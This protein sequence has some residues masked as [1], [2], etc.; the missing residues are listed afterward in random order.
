MKISLALA[1]A[2]LGTAAPAVI[3]KAADV[4]PTHVA[5]PIFPTL[6]CIDD[7]PEQ[8]CYWW[9]AESKAHSRRAEAVADAESSDDEVEVSIG[10][11]STST[12]TATKTSVA[13]TTKIQTKTQAAPTTTRTATVTSTKTASQATSSATSVESLDDEAEVFLD[14]DLEEFQTI[15]FYS[16]VAHQEDTPYPYE[17]V[18]EDYNRTAIH[19]AIATRRHDRY[20]ASGCATHCNEHRACDAFA[21]YIER[22]PPCNN[23]SNPENVELKKCDLYNTRLQRPDVRKESEKQ[24]VQ[25]KTITRAVRAYNGY[26]RIQK[27]ATVTATRTRTVTVRESG[28]VE[29]SIAYRTRTV[30]TTAR[31]A[32][33]TVHHTMSF[34]R[35]S[36]VTRSA[37]ASTRTVTSTKPTTTVTKTSTTSGSASKTTVTKTSTQSTATVTKTSTRSGSSK[38]TTVTQTSTKST[39]TV[40]QTLTKS[41]ATVTKTS[42]KSGSAE[43]TT[44]TVTSTKTSSDKHTTKTR[45]AM[46]TTTKSLK[47][48][49]FTSTQTRTVVIS[50]SAST[51]AEAESSDEEGAM[52]W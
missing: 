28:S 13:T 20:D 45:T 16:R 32:T 31:P 3:T 18:I 41:T 1:L 9:K 25:G 35:N 22:E 49:T 8:M 38:P 34:G 40:T 47:T 15:P 12:K 50:A 52:W 33:T 19:Q 29:V 36:T 24:D 26:N 46:F 4:P 7:W 27:T 23:C 39:A 44:R 37:P 6:D 51:G 17:L 42:T 14:A 5:K 2:G 10:P 48:T 11:G 43:P 21:I 30:I